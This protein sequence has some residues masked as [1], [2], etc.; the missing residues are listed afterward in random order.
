MTRSGRFRLRRMPHWGTASLAPRP[1]SPSLRL[2]AAPTHPVPPAV[3]PRRP[4]F[5]GGWA[6]AIRILNLRAARLERFASLVSDDS[7]GSLSASPN[8]PLGY[9]FPRS[10]ACLFPSGLSCLLVRRTS[11]RFRLGCAA[12]PGANRVVTSLARRP[13]GVRAGLASSEPLSGPSVWR[14][15]AL[16]PRCPFRL[17]AICRARLGPAHCGSCG[18]R[19]VGRAPAGEKMGTPPPS[20]RQRDFA[21]LDSRLIALLVSLLYICIST[22]KK[23][24]PCIG[25]VKS[26][27]PCTA[28][29]LQLLT[30]LPSQG[31]CMY[32]KRH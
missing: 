10:P 27:L 23:M 4:R 24:A 3:H 7:F 17:C 12:P 20:P 11:H 31:A 16:G 19:P 2:V 32:D 5:R 14:I 21:P 1:A 15:C 9:R 8:S 22:N 6:R 18:R 30:G 28:T 13:R 26:I 29:A 25:P